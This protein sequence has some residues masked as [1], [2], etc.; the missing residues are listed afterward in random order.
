[1]WGSD[2][3]VSGPDYGTT[4]EP[5]EVLVGSLS[6]HEQSDIWSGTAER[7]YGKMLPATD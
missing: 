7:T 6:A 3:P 1:M 5:I 4:H 2:W